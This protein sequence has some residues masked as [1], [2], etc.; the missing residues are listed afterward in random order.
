M[1]S[2]Y[3]IPLCDSMLKIIPIKNSVRAQDDNFPGFNIFPEKVIN[4]LLGIQS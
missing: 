2:I 3:G 4:N 1:T